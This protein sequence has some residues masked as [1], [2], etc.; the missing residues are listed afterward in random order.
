MTAGLPQPSCRLVIRPRGCQQCCYTPCILFQGKLQSCRLS[1]NAST[2]RHAG[3]LHRLGGECLQNL[4]CVCSGNR[5]WEAAADNSKKHHSPSL[6]YDAC[7]FCPEHLEH[8]D[9]LDSLWSFWAFLQWS[10][11]LV[12]TCRTPNWDYCTQPQKI[13]HALQSILQQM[14]LAQWIFNSR[15][16][17]RSNNIKQTLNTER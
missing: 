11:C 2:C 10:G 13:I 1:K 15:M 3:F 7:C 12:L 8:V 9:H 5:L 16:K 14:T 4:W 6:K 17:Q